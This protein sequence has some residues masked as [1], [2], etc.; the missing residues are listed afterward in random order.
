MRAVGK[1]KLDLEAVF[2]A[3]NVYQ[4]KGKYVFVIL[5]LNSSVNLSINTYR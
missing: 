2:Q 4:A 3:A 1:G 5:S